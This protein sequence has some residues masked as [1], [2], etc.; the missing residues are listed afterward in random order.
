MRQN[1]VASKP[2]FLFEPRNRP[3]VDGAIS[4][5]YRITY[6]LVAGIIVFGGILIAGIVILFFAFQEA[7]LISELEKNGVTIQATV[8][9]R[10]IEDNDGGNTYKLR[11][12]YQVKGI[13]YQ[14]TQEVT[15]KAYNQSPLN[16]Q[17]SIRYLP[18]N[19]ANARIMGMDVIQ[20]G[21]LFVGVAFF[22][23]G[24]V[25]LGLGIY[26][27][28]R[29]RRRERL[30]CVVFGE[31]T[32]VREENDEG[33]IYLHAHYLFINPRNEVVAGSCKRSN[34]QFKKYGL[35]PIGTAIAILY[36]GDHDYELI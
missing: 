5:Y 7:Q 12:S 18:N 33:T 23:I 31:L 8:N 10:T 36:L 2:L 24:F 14:N 9:N 29:S 22:L 35:P 6:G 15:E 4:T 17:V 21:T 16:S 28:R 11:Y 1:D 26:F 19:P 34:S 30:G 3:F 13:T 32:S 25:T 27:Y 20:W